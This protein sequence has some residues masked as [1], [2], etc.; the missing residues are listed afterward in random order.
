MRLALALSTCVSLS[1]VACSREPDNVLVTLAPE[2]VSSI[3]GVASVRAVV[4]AE[5]EPLPDEAVTLTVAYTDRNGA[6]HD[7]APITG[8]TDTRGAFETEVTGL[9]WD[10][11]GTITVALTAAT[12]VAGQ[13]PFAVIDRTPPVASIT[14]PTVSRHVIQGQD[15]VV[16]VH[17]QDEI[18]VS[19]VFL[20]ASG[21]L[22]RL[23]SSVV[24][25][26]SADAMVDFELQVPDNAL[27]GGTITLHALAGDLS[28]N[29][30][31]AEPVE[32][33][34]DARP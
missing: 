5:N 29:L 9:D 20:E 2:V 26:G 4:L 30:S 23:R 18:G 6:T 31:A 24:A 21:E 25:S 3:D 34:V 13:A 11:S 16:P 7:I 19:E 32:L 15:I 28:G 1:L 8:T 27:V 22:T 33:T 10:G 14:P 17:V 12:D